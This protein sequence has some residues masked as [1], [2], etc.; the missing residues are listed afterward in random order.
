ML[1]RKL[2]VGVVASILIV[3]L[4]ALLFACSQTPTSVPVRTFERAQRMDV[5]CV[6]L[7]DPVTQRPVE[8]LGR[9]QDECAPVPANVDGNAFQ[10]Q[11]F[12]LVTQTTR[13]ELAVVNLSAGFLVDQSR[14]TPG[15]NF[16]PVGALPTDVATTPDGKMAFVASAEANKAAIYGIPTRR[17]LGDT[18]N[19]FPHDPNPATLATWPVCALPQNPAALAIVPRTGA[20]LPA[21]PD[22]GTSDAGDAGDAGDGGDAGAPAATDVPEYEVVVVLPGDRRNSAKIVTI[23]PRPFRRGALPIKPDGTLDF[24]SDPT[25]TPGPTL[26]PGSLA[27]CPITSA[28]EL[29]GA[30]SVPTTFK[31]GPRWDDG[32]KYVDGGVDLTCLLPTQA[33]HCG[34]PPCCADTTITPSAEGGTDSG[35]VEAGAPGVDAGA[36]KPV[37]APDAGPVPLA[38]GPLDPP[39]VVSI[40]RDDQIV[41][42]A[43]EGVPFIHAVDLTTP[44]APRELP[45]LLATSL[46]DPGR[47]VQVKDLALSPPTR[48]YKRFLYAVDRVDGSL[49]I[50]DV[51]DPATTQRTPLTRPH[52]ELNPFQPP[53]RIAF[54]S[55]VVAVA[56]ARHDVPLAHINNVLTPSAASGVLCNPN[57]N[58]DS[59]PSLDLGFYYRASSTDPG[60][61]IGP[62]RLRGVYG[63]ATLANGQVVAIDVDDWDSPCRRPVV[64]NVPISDIAPPEPPPTS[65]SDIAPYHVPVA[66]ALSVT[67][68]GF[69]PMTAPHSLRSEVLVRDDPT[70]GNN[71]PRLQGTATISVNG[72]VL[73]QVG[74]G[75]ERTPLLDPPH[76]ATE[77]PQVHIDQD[78]TA[79]YEGAL[80]G[81]DGLSGLLSTEDGYQS[82]LLRQPQAHFCAKGVE[83]W[84]QGIERTN[85]IARELVKRGLTPAPGADRLTTDYIQ[86]T[87]DI[88]GPDDDYWNID[89]DCWDP[90]VARGRP[91]QDQCVRTFGSASDQSTQRDFPIIQAFDDRVVLGRFFTTPAKT[92]E[93]VYSDASNVATL[94]RMKCCF[95]NQARFRVRTANL[96]AMT[97][98]APGGLPGSVGFF[99]HVAA[100]SA[101]RCVVSCDPRESLLNGRI[102]TAPS[103]IVPTTIGRNSALG[104]RNPMFDTRIIGAL[105]GTIPARDTT[106][107]FSTRG[108]FRA[109]FVSIGGASTAVSPQSMRFIPTL[110]QIGVVDGASQGLVLI[111][112]RQVTVARAPFF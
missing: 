78:W 101:G 88:L 82:L 37:T 96:W 29:V 77:T 52:P 23:D 70:T 94:K 9:P 98:V 68:E 62:R 61:D 19:R 97:G 73:P 105:D 26:A 84:A 8:P 76:F 67:N 6:Q 16:L 95:H 103:G 57:P 39:K 36:C 27:A 33:A 2:V 17:I 47:V 31:P 55:P 24:T 104:M 5:L 56:F 75:S 69:F 48:D 40:V 42:I 110:G 59:N 34:L 108:R 32:V 80:P 112:L 85:A 11:L 10:K 58:L 106:Y 92:R 43:D 93:V 64:M 91:R 71:L 3:A 50:Y 12:A 100:D 87:E 18:D 25:L 20:P 28:I 81:F 63:F 99:S 14:A 109:L 83:D 15:I 4:A 45:P 41:Y 107:T 86:L 38:L 51:T 53:D 35:A 65:T 54:G 1:R 79:T 66:G 74:A 49:M 111:D 89:Q 21:A 13:G 90:S 46:L 60:Q 44:G 102:P 72:V 7:Y 30:T 22:G